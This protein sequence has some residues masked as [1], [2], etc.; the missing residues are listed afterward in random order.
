MIYNWIFPDFYTAILQEIV[1][2]ICVNKIYIHWCCTKI[3]SGSKAS[4]F[5]VTDNTI[6]KG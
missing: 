6:D 4:H 2:K 5:P 3:P 1:N